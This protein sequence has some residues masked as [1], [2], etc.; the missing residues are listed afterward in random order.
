MTQALMRTDY[1]LADSLE[2]TSGQVFLTGTQ[3]LIRLAL[4]QSA[5]DDERGIRSAG[6]ISGY[7]GSP[8][9]GYD[10]ALW[11]AKKHLAAQNIV[12]TPGVNEELAATATR[13]R[14]R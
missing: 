2:A 3:A 5:R 9:G 12:F 7:R 4:M 14:F 6:F 8:L 11:Q 13:R 1:R 10:Q